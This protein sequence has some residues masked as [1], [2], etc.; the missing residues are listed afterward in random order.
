MTKIENYIDG[1]FLP[2]ENNLYLDNFDPST[3]SVYSQIPDSNA[4]DVEKAIHVAEKAFPAWANAR[5]EFRARILFRISELIDQNLEMLAKAE[6]IDQGKI[7]RA[8]V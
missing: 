7:G 8:H 1:K 6:S 4:N 3:A 2:P 5:P